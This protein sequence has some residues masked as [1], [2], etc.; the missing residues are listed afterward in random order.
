MNPQKIV[1]RFAPSPTGYFHAGSYRTAL[2]SWIFARQNNGKFILRIEDTDRERSKKE[3]EENIIESLEWL[4]LKYDEFYRQSDRTE[5]YKGYIQKLI[6][7]GHAYVS[8]E[9]EKG[10]GSDVMTSAD[11]QRRSDLAS[12]AR[13]T[14]AEVIRFKNPNKKVTFNDLIRGPIEFDTTELGDFVIAKSFEEPVFHLVVVLDDHEM[15]VTHVIRGEDHISNT[16]RQ[17]LIYEAL[18]APIPLYA[19]IPLILAK[20]RSK[21][22]KRNGAVAVNE[23]RNRGYLADAVVNYLSLLGWHPSDEREVLTVD[24]IVKEFDLGRIQKGG[25]IFDEEKLA[26]FNRQYILKLSDEAFTESV[27]PFVP[28]WMMTHSPIFK[29]ILPL[30]REKI[31]KFSDVHDLLSPSG[32]LGFVKQLHSYPK[33]LLLWKKNPDP[34]ATRTHLL[35]AQ[36]LMET[37]SDSSFTADTIKQALWAYAEA[38]GKGDVLWPLRVALTAK[39]KSPDPFIS[40]T[41]LGKEESLKRITAGAALLVS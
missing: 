13:S 7:S 26:W 2:F 30:L 19:H 21:L 9:A 35:K 1:T 6:D 3:Y 23:Y 28:E 38:H 17:I 10:E 27:T 4:G 18:G 29:R 41:I 25:A 11:G 12:R 14:R 24:E 31:G 37:V 32:E 39:E 33:E 20:D 36:E 8:K 22:S 5:I 40:A 16:P 34:G 15:G